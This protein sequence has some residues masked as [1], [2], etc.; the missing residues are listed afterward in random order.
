[1]NNYCGLNEEDYHT[2]RCRSPPAAERRKPLWVL[3]WSPQRHVLE[4]AGGRG[5]RKDAQGLSCWGAKVLHHWSEDHS[6]SAQGMDS[7]FVPED[8][9]LATGSR[10]RTRQLSTHPAC[11]PQV[12]P[13]PLENLIACTYFSFFL[14][15]SQAE[16]QPIHQT[17]PKAASLLLIGRPHTAGHPPGC[18]QPA[19]SKTCPVQPPAMDGSPCPFPS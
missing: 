9:L 6:L 16:I 18:L 3:C 17:C 8:A 7:M 13:F 10:A 14:S 5:G 19:Q 2:F 15:F 4:Q 1:M 12:S 11:P